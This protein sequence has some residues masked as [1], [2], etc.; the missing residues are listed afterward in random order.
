MKYKR[1]TL[2]EREQIFALVNQGKTARK[3]AEILGR[4]HTTIVRE[5]KK[6]GNISNYSPSKAYCQA[7]KCNLQKGRKRVL[8]SRPEVFEEVF[9]RLFLKFSPEQISQ[10]IKK[11]SADEPLMWIAHETI[12]RYIYAFP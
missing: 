12:Y 4:S 3:I 9:K 10:T 11:E 2:E 6:C 5:L 7:N 8:D 1:L